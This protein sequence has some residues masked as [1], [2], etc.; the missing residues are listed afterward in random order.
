M[1]QQVN[2]PPNSRQ[3]PGSPL[4]PPTL[5][6]ACAA[7]IAFGLAVGFQSNW[8][9]LPYAVP[10]AVLLS[11]PRSMLR[12]RAPLSSIHYRR[13]RS[14]LSATRWASWL[15]TLAGMAALALFHRTGDGALSATIG[16]VLYFICCAIF[17]ACPIA[18]S[19]ALRM[20]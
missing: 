10:V 15:L 9:F 3:G 20:R 11:L 2:T 14:I 8:A 16:T 7:T 17:V 4:E 13:V 5:A 12:R 6:G 19:L 18:I 1:E